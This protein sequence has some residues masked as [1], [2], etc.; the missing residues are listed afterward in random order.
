[1]RSFKQYL[2]E[3]LNISGIKVPK[4][5]DEDGNKVYEYLLPT[6]ILKVIIG[7]NE[8][9]AHSVSFAH[10]GEFGNIPGVEHTPSETMSM[11]N[12][13]AA[14]LR[15]HSKR[16]KASEY[17]YYTPHKT[18]HDIYQRIAKLVGVN[19]TNTVPEKDIFNRHDLK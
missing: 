3:G 5:Y 8:D 13:V 19:A 12:R 14:T 11:L 17:I 15:N 18:K 7:P 4:P 10:G 1:M 6:D 9:G 2:L 16:Y